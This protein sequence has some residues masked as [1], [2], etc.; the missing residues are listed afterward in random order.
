MLVIAR[1]AVAA[2]VGGSHAYLGWARS[3]IPAKTPEFP[4]D[5]RAKPDTS[6]VVHRGICEP[7]RE[8]V[9]R[10]V[11][12]I[13]P[14]DTV[15]VECLDAVGASGKMSDPRVLSPLTHRGSGA[16]SDGVKIRD[17]GGLD[18]ERTRVSGRDTGS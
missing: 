12:T 13:P 16:D 2:G 17:R 7:A 5:V 6:W 8:A 11:C 10:T 15:I 18:T 9:V 1:A 14:C 4:A 3:V